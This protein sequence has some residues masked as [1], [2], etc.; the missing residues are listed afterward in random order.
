MKSTLLFF[1]ALATYIVALALPALHGTG[2]SIHGISLL[3]L[4]WVQVPV[5][6]V[7]WLANLTFVT[8]AMLFLLKRY[9]GSA[10]FAATSVLVGLDTF[11]ATRFSVDSACY[12][13]AIEHVGSAFY[14]WQL[15]FLLLGVASVLRASANNSFKPN[16]LRESA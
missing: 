15:S 2:K 1:L 11:R 5:E 14:G 7:A 3:L 4:G 9:R 10:V 8:S 13:I 6:C 12:N 16:S